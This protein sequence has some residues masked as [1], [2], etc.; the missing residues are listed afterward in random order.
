MSEPHVKEH[1]SAYLDDMLTPPEKA[2]VDGHLSDCPECRQILSDLKNM[3]AWMKSVPKPSP[4]IGLKARLLA[5]LNDKESK[6]DFRFPWLYVSGGLTTAVAAFLVFGV[7]QNGRLNKQVAP[8]KAPRPVDLAGPVGGKESSRDI[9]MGLDDQ[10]SRGSGVG[11]GVGRG[12][13]A[14][15]KKKRVLKKAEVQSKLAPL[16]ASKPQSVMKQNA[17]IG[18]RSVSAPRVL[19]KRKQISEGAVLDEV[20][21]RRGM[22]TPVRAIEQ[23]NFLD[24]DATRSDYSGFASNINKPEEL[25]IRTKEELESLLTRM[26]PQV[27][28][29]LFSS[30][31]FSKRM[32]AAVFMGY[33]PTAG[34][35]IRIIGEEFRDEPEGRTLII[36]IQSTTP[37][38]GAMVAQMLTQPYHLKSLPVFQGPVRFQHVN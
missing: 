18:Q 4:N 28:D 38:K 9:F 26:G 32:I 3:G 5:Q 13:I 14:P 16:P 7:L 10:K 12:K 23:E 24:R 20:R 11:Y 6:K 37:P 30:L 17:G 8:F 27:P 35:R 1:L 2:R 33:Q 36:T 25:I 21:G 31:D 29:S 15:A 22:K 34:Y 19:S